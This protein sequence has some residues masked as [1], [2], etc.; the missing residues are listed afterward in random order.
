MLAVAA[1]AAAG[2]MAQ[3]N[4]PIPADPELRT[5]KL[6]NGM[7]YYIRH[8]DKPKGQADFYI[9]HDV[10]AIQ[11]ND[12]QQ[13]LAHFLEHMAFNGTKNLPGKQLTEY[14]E[15]VGVK[16]G[17]NLNAGT[18][19]D[20]TIYNISDVPTS[21]EGIIDSAL[22]ILHDWS[23]FIA[24]EPKEIDS[25]R[26]VI[27]EELRTRDGASWRSTMKL[28]QALGKGTKYEHRNL[29]GYLDGLKN[30]QHK[31]LEDFYAQWYRPDYQAVVVV[32]DIDVDAVESKIKALMADI[33]APAADASHKE[34]IVVPDNEEPIVSIFTDPEMQGTKVQLFIKRPAL[35]KQMGNTIVAEANNVIEAYMTTMENAR[36]QEIA[37]QPDAPF[38]GAGMG[39]GDVI[40]IIPTLNATVFVAMTQD[41]KLARGFEALYTELEKVRRYGF[42]QGE[43]E[44]AQENLMR[45]AERTY[46]NR[47]DRRNGE[48][49]Q[50]YLNNYSKNSPI[51]DAET[52]WQLDSMLIKMLN[53]DAVNAFAAQTIT[54]ANQVIIV[55][56]PEK[57]GLTTPTAEELLA[58]RDKVAAGEVTA[59][60]DNVVKEPLIPEGTVLKGSPV[61]KTAEDAKL[62]TTEWTLANGAKVVVKHTDFKA[63]EVRMSAV[64]KGGL[65]V[66]SDGEFYMGEM[67]PAVNSM[68]GVGKF[69]A[70]ELKKQLSGKSASVQPAVENYSSA[71]K[72]VCSPKDIETMLQ[73]LYLNFTQPR[74]DRADYD[75][76][77]KM[78]RS[79]LENARTNPDF[80]M[81]EKVIDVTYGDNPRRQMISNEIV[82]KFDFEQLPAIYAKLYPGAN[83]FVFTFV[84][85]IDPETLKPLVEKYIGSIPAAKKPL[86]YIDDKVAPV[87]GEVTEEFTAPMQQPKVS[88]LYYYSGKMPY[89]FKDRMALSFLAQALNSRYLIS[90]REEKGGTYG[91]RVKGSTEYIPHQTY[92]MTISFDT[93][94]EMADELC[95][96]VLKEIQEIAENGPK[97]EDIEKNREFM[98]K[99]WKN[100]LELNQ[101]WMNYIQAKYGS[102]LNYVGEYEQAVRDLTNADV[103]A[104]AKKILADGNLVKVVMRPAKT[105]E[106]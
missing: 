102:G 23:H 63:D 98:L 19:W 87:K 94:E 73:L 34:T 26:G 45:Q 78:V 85:N 21:R 105:E 20:Q 65:S 60:E 8:N 32:G 93:N 82:N 54:P 55:N 28:L 89:T 66:L 84:G 68:S 31:E 1:F 18:S 11:E 6:E 39:T 86:N 37:M 42:T 24:L 75:N 58:I 74:F 91:V 12:S 7:T 35:P 80:L 49:V 38:L 88:V 95:E 56:A 47:N 99:N 101:G 4:Q 83:G 10:G 61:K 52:E 33:P 97:T 40:G 69:S 15:T 48:F 64:A 27:M 30:F 41:G 92:D 103:Q 53:V 22:L 71:M 36:L 57:E 5:G 62:G 43:F 104:L 90:I 50:S 106:K 9:L 81:Q 76:L 14:L 3:M 100:S 59:Y 67:M 44:R 17:A 16:F 70:T 25:E 77:I 96:I 51:P 2:A 79:Q 72:G 29:I 13:G 46:A